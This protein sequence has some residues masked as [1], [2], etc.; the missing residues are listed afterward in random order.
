[1]VDALAR[2]QLEARR[3]GWTVRLRDAPAELCE[4]LDLAGLAPLLLELG[5]QTE[6]VEQVGS[7]E[8]VEPRDPS[9]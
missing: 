9:P 4:L 8:V 1:M 3:A 7:E 6:G 2:L 5:R